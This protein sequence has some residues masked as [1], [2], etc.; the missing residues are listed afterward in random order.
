MHHAMYKN[1]AI[2]TALINP[3]LENEKS[4]QL[5]KTCEENNS[6]QLTMQFQISTYAVHS[7]LLPFTAIR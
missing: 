7:R 6:K 3:K 5:Y 1:T 4:S 2:L